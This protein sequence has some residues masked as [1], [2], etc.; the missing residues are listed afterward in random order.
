MARRK[1]DGVAVSQPDLPEFL[2]D[3]ITR[4]EQGCFPTFTDEERERC[5]TLHS[6]LSPQLINDPN[7]KGKGDPKKVLRE[8]LLMISWDRATGSWKWAIGDKMLNTSWAGPLPTIVGIAEQ[9]ELCL[10]EGR[11][12]VRKKKVS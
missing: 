9:I 11:F 7:H 10:T 1:P 5:P 4:A 3:S 8:P 12:S 6:V 2:A